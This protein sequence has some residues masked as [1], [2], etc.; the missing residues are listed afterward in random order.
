M[1]IRTVCGKIKPV[2][3]EITLLYEHIFAYLWTS[4]QSKEKNQIENKKDFDEKISLDNFGKIRR[5]S[6]SLKDNV[7]LT[8]IDLITREV[9]YFKNDGGSCIVDATPIGLFRS[10]SAL[11]QISEATGVHIIASTGFYIAE[12]LDAQTR[13]RSAKSLADQMVEE[14]TDGIDNTGIKAGIIGEIG[15]PGEF[16]SYEEKIL[17]AAAYA[18]KRTGAAISLHTCCPNQMHAS[19]RKASWKQR[20][21]EVLDYLEQNGADITRVM[22]GHADTTV[23][24]D[25]N[26]HRQI[27]K[28][29][30]Y[31]VYD[32]FQQEHPYDMYNT[33]APTDWQ[34][35]MNIVALS[36]EGFTK[37]LIISTDLWQKAMLKEYG[38][39]GLS[40]IINNVCPMLE[41]NG[42]N[43]DDIECLLVR[44]PRKILA[45][46]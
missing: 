4:Y 13:S 20:V 36:E 12:A 6:S 11:K 31:I 41:K 8:D 43:K 5:D 35:V 2:E 22:V 25:I 16:D 32:N 45:F 39:W 23:E 28:R 34:R 38:G 33:Y 17:Q 46:L 42:L 10:P 30:A 18:Q 1:H 9:G 40:H 26:D 29:G 7:I 21:M 37:Q 44:N 27:L 14:I 15:A 24:F 19:K 3:M